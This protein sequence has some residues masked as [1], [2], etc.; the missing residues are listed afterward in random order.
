MVVAAVVVRAQVVVGPFFLSHLRVATQPGIV[1]DAPA[2]VPARRQA[3][4]RKL[5]PNRGQRQSD[6]RQRSRRTGATA[7]P[8]RDRRRVL[9]RHN[10]GQDR[11]RARM[12]QMR[13]MVLTPIVHP[14]GVIS[15]SAVS[16]PMPQTGRWRYCAIR[17]GE[18]KQT[19]SYYRCFVTGFVCRPGPLRRHQ[20]RHPIGRRPAIISPGF[21]TASGSCSTN[22]GSCR[23]GSPSRTTVGCPN[24]A[25]ASPTSCRG[26][27][28]AST[29]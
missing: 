28:R 5:R 23:S 16:P 27:R 17:A 3:D 26:R 2:A 21:R 1:G 24:G 4:R 10:R 12:R 7:D 25:S 11:S 13:A 20:S 19:R 18:P 22:R 29:R 6:R 14:F 9:R 15:T 8:R